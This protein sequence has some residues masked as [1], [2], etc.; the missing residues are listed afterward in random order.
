MKSVINRAFSSNKTNLFRKRLNRFR[1]SSRADEFLPYRDRLENLPYPLR[2]QM[3]TKQFTNLIC[4][5]F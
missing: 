3:R 5:G 4:Y 1:A 2:S